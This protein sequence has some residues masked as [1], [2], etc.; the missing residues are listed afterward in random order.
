MYHVIGIKIEGFPSR[1]LEI[2]ARAR[3]PLK[4]ARF[5]RHDVIIVRVVPR[6]EMAGT[7]ESVPRRRRLHALNG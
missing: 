7:S 6:R 1:F 5:E 4:V 2:R 3:A